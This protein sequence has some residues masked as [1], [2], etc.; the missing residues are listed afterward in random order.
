MLTPDS[1][2]LLVVLVVGA[3]TAFV[4][5]RRP[6][7][8]L[9]ILVLGVPFRDLSTRWLLAHS[10]WSLSA[11]TALG[12]WWFVVVAVL[13]GVVMLR[14]WRSGHWAGS[15]IRLDWAYAL[16][17]GI[18]L[19]G[20]IEVL[21]SS[22]RGA[23]FT[24]LRGYLQPMGVFLIARLLRPSPMMLR[25]LLAAWLGV[26][27][28]IAAFGLWQ[29]AL[30]TADTYRAEGYLRQDGSLVVP[31]ADMAERLYLRPSSTVSGP[32]ELG[33]DMV[34]LTVLC[35][36]AIPGAGGRGRVL[37]SVLAALFTATLVVSFSR[38]GLLAFLAAWAAVAYLALS[39][40]RFKLPSQARTR[41]A[42]GAIVITGVVVTYLSIQRLG[43]LG[44]LAATLSGLQSEYHFQDTLSGVRHLIAHP[45]GVGL[46]LV[47]PKGALSLMQ[48][49]GVFHVE[50]S[51]LQIA[52]EMGV[53]GLALWLVFWA[54]LL[55]QASRAWGRLRTG[56][57][58]AITA[59]AFAGWIGSLVAFTFLPLMQSISLMVW[60]W[61]LLGTATA[62]ESEGSRGN[63]ANERSPSG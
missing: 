59:T 26:G 54:G 50:G 38:S 29:A 6:Y 4:G 23:A 39:H 28:L 2:T 62:D 53:W 34:V 40:G 16:L 12:R 25:R 51:L 15:G 10:G 13:L 37:L 5:W 27:A 8:V 35:G 33:L 31:Q 58:R 32:N 45:A 55:A 36:M 1:G 3:A 7:L 49:G 18:V 21:A 44:V 20:V 9:A 46:G 17:A 60:L 47:E 42:V 52:E 56:P 43:L 14:R 22:N 61:F 41:W 48:V 19:L 11:V 30:W 24:S 57:L 63:A